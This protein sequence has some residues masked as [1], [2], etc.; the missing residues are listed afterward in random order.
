MVTGGAPGAPRMTAEE[1]EA[2]LPRLGR[3]SLDTVR[4]ARAVVVEGQ[5][6][7]EAARLH[8]LT[9]QRVNGILRR[10]ELARGEVPK[11]WRRVDVW[12]P[13]DLAEYVETMARQARE[14]ASEGPAARAG[15]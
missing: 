4:I 10:F 6:P 15:R 1:F 2:L 7:A 12:L 8:G 5:R 9:R 14:R 11:G 13:P 3:L